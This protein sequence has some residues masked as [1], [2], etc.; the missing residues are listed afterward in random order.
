MSMKMKKLPD[1]ELEIMLIIWKA[2]DAISTGEVINQ[3]PQDDTR[4]LQTVQNLLSRLCEKEFI[5]CKK[6]GKLNYYKPIIDEVAYRKQETKSLL[7]RFYGNSPKGLF[8]TLVN[9]KSISKEDIEEIRKM[10][11][12]GGE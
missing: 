1:S 4:K 12:Q 9:E 5:E 7:G 6:M 8:A 10:I 11:E 2:N 3:L